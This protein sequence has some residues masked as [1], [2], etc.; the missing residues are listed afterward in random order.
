VYLFR[1]K[2]KKKLE[3]GIKGRANGAMELLLRVSDIAYLCVEATGVLD[4][5]E[6]TRKRGRE[7]IRP[8][9]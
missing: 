6:K 4:K 5:A 1:K 7:D 3:R 9:S 2:G 8:G